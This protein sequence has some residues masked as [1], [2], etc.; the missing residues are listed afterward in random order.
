VV[1][2]GMQWTSARLAAVGRSALWASTAVFITWDDWGGWYDH[3]EPPL[4]DTWKNGGP[5]GGPAYAGT[6]FSYGPRVGCLVISPYVRKG[7]ISKTLHSHA[8][9]AK[10]CE[11]TFGLPALSAR[12]AAADD[13]SDCFDF[14][15]TPLPPPVP[16]AGGDPP[17]L[18]K[19]KGPPHHRRKHPKKKPTTGPS[20]GTP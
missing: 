2:V 9:V 16:S 1:S 5:A 14:A 6:Q 10:F 15:Q 8:S 19:P 13:M 3:V 17:P 12:D 18:P 11:T 20:A 7:Y 4:K